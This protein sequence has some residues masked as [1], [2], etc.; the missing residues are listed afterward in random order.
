M[1]HSQDNLTVSKLSKLQQFILKAAVANR[2]NKV[3]LMPER[4][5]PRAPLPF[6]N[7]FI[8]EEISR[9]D[10]AVK[11]DEEN[12]ADL[13]KTEIMEGFFGF[14]ATW[15]QGQ[16][17]AIRNGNFY[18][19]RSYMGGKQRFDRQKIGVAKY[20]GAAVSVIRALHRLKERRL[21]ELFEGLQAHFTAL[22]LTELGVAVAERL[23]LSGL[24]N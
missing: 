20:Q 8:I 7:V 11:Q 16:M 1:L 10:A 15:W 18:E 21:I 5:N 19:A 24:T 2:W 6:Y 9:Y 14:E 23:A 3:K 17:Y 12:F 4:R 13:Y 22:K